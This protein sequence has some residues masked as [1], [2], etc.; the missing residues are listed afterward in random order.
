MPGYQ[1][2]NDSVGR[3]SNAEENALKMAINLSDIQITLQLM[4]G[5][6]PMKKKFET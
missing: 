4:K 6:K 2:T 5:Y 3:M 1:H